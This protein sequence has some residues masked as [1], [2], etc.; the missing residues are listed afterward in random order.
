MARIYGNRRQGRWMKIDDDWIN[1]DS[2]TPIGKFGRFIWNL[3]NL[4]YLIFGIII[5]IIFNSMFNIIVFKFIYF[6]FN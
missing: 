4:F 2:K 1:I 5:I 6:I 3:Q